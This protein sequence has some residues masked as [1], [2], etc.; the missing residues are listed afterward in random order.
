[1]PPSRFVSWRRVYHPLPG[2][3]RYNNPVLEHLIRALAHIMVPMFFVGMI[4]S[5]LVVITTVIRDLNEVLR[6]DDEIDD[7]DL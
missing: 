5:G 6:A 2:S 7:P 3:Q 4:G 1:M